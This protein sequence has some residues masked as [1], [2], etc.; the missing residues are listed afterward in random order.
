M[1]ANNGAPRARLSKKDFM[2]SKI[3]VLGEVL[4]KPNFSSITK[5]EYIEKG[6]ERIE[7]A[8]TKTPMYNKPLIIKLS[9]YWL[10]NKSR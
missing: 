4:L 7:P 3:N 10:I 1:S 8:K 2:R 6:S 9:E 5:V